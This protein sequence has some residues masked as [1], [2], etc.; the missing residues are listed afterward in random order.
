[1]SF[2]ESIRK[3][4]ANLDLDIRKKP[5]GYS[6]Y[7][8]QK[9]TPDVLSFIA[10]CVVN[11]LGGKTPD[12]VFT[13]KD[14]WDFQYFQKNTV[15]IFGKPSPINES[16]KS[17][18]D[19]FIAQP[20]KTLAFSKILNEEKAGMRNVYQIAQPDLLEYISQNERNAWLFLVAYIEKVLSDS[21]FI[22]E[23]NTYR[24]KAISSGATQKDFELLK[25]EFETF[26]RGY[27]NITG[28]VEIR[29]IFPKVL[30]PYAAYTMINGSEDGRMTDNRFTYSDLMYNRENFRD[31]GKD[32]ALTRGEAEAVVAEKPELSAYKVQKAKNIIKR[33]HT[34]SEIH[35]SL[36]TG[37]ATQ[38][39]HIFPEHEF[40]Q[41][42]SYIENLILLTP[43]QH[44]TR[45][46]PSN[47]TQSIDR[48][49]QRE[50]LLAKI[51]SIEKSIMQGKDV[52]S[53]ESFIHVINVGLSLDLSTKMTFDELKQ[54]VSKFYL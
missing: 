38:V 13:I 30:N 6:R 19:K 42:S 52:Y 26:M 17:E 54:T 51:D 3:Y 27:T 39:H 4:L 11:F 12:T 45:A 48:D 1:M 28:D 9:V 15:A 34:A 23:L 2:E 21:G 37:E 36:A 53:K 32:K 31:I 47:N 20:L 46:H 25:G 5:D 50:C 49:Y 40:P 24:E 44:N 16:A 29:R 18:Y 14:I 33:N 7:M 43:Q 8:D 22:K 10:D 41:V 35:D